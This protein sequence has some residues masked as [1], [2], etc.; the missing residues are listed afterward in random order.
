MELSRELGLALAH[1]ERVEFSLL[2]ARAAIS[3]GDASTAPGSPFSSEPAVK[4]GSAVSGLSDD[5]TYC[6]ATL[7][8]RVFVT[9]A[10][11]CVVLPRAAEAR[12]CPQ[13]RAWGSGGTSYRVGKLTHTLTDIFTPSLGRLTHVRALRHFFF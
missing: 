6:R 10:S 8:V 7:E 9:S 5:G 1:Q 2:P 4:S 13:G 11:A 12:S 3:L